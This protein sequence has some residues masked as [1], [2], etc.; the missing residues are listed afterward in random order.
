MSVILSE[1]RFTSERKRLWMRYKILQEKTPTDERW[2][3]MEKNFLR[4][5]RCYRSKKVL[6][7]KTLRF[8]EKYQ[9]VFQEE[10]RSV[11][12]HSIELMKKLLW[13]KKLN[14]ED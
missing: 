11:I 3:K 5:E 14:R 7:I 1:E 10:Q 4:M 12:T 13:Q 9:R 2:N 6:S 8:F